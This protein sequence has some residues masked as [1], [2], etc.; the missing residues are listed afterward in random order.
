MSHIAR[1]E[2]FQQKNASLQKLAQGGFEIMAEGV[3]TGSID[4]TKSLNEHMG[5]DDFAQLYSEISKVTGL[6]HQDHR[7]YSGID[8][9][10][11][12]SVDISLDEVAKNFASENIQKP[13]RTIRINDI[14]AVRE[15]MSA[16][17]LWLTN[18]VARMVMNI[19]AKTE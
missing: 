13:E 2:F 17:Q 12:V 19:I 15:K 3:G 18:Q 4:A 16:P 9:E 14:R 6:D 5:V 8:K 7:L 11:I 1:P 10:K